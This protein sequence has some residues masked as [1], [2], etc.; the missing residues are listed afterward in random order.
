MK[1]LKRFLHHKLLLSFLI[2]AVMLVLFLAF[3]RIMYETNDDGAISRLISIFGETSIPY[4]NALLSGLLG[5]LQKAVP[6][7][8]VFVLYQLVAGYLSFCAITY[9]FLDKFNL[10]FSL[11]ASLAVVILFGYNHYALIQYTKT[12]YLLSIAGFLLLIHAL[13]KKRSAGMCAA[14]GLL[15][16]FGCFTRSDSFYVAAAFTGVFL[17]ALVVM[18]IAGRKKNTRL[19]LTPLL[20]TRKKQ[21][22][23]WVLFGAVVL[24]SAFASAQVYSGR[25]GFDEYNRFNQAR[26]ATLDYPIPNYSSNQEFYSQLG[27]DQNDLNMYRSW[28]I[29][30]KVFTAEKLE[31]IAELQKEQQP[32]IVEYY[33]Q[34]I[35]AFLHE[36]SSALSLPV[37]SFIVL[38]LIICAALFF[39]AGFLLKRYPL[40][41]AVFCTIW[42]VTLYFAHMKAYRG[43]FYFTILLIAAAFYMALSQR[44]MAVVPLSLAGLSMALVMYLAYTQRLIYRAAYGIFLCAI[45]LLIYS[46]EK[47]ALRERVQRAPKSWKRWAAVSACAALII[48]GG[49]MLQGLSGRQTH[50]PVK[51]GLMHYL[52]QNQDK[53]YLKNAAAGG[54]YTYNMEYPLK[55]F[56]SYQ[57]ENLVSL[58]SWLSGSKYEEELLRRY[59]ITNLYEDMID[60]PNVF[61]IAQT[62]TIQRL[63]A[64]YNRHYSRPGQTKIVCRKV[65]TAGGTPLYRLVTVPN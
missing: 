44:K 30:T 33:T 52:E 62:G 34:K 1:N 53:L 15:A 25:E 61:V 14:G 39:G 46:V 27:L 54:I 21:L 51:Q 58:G 22:I 17:L 57:C 36:V 20:Q 60:N 55:P 48:C 9:V 45:I 65:D 5:G 18:W 31:K 35:E 19:T 43:L 7:C 41:F 29:D 50:Y 56:D 63:E 47:G 3:T 59:G 37:G 64:Y 12:A 16:L 23:S 8:N 11:P 40:L 32:S 26:T 4:L 24:A 6:F 28:N 2:N 10:K 38:F 13:Y 49:L 42:A